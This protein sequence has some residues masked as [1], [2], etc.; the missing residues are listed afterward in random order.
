MAKRY[1]AKVE[2]FEIDDSNG[3]GRDKDTRTIHA[4]VADFTVRATDLDALKDKLTQHIEL[5]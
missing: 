1:L 3:T 5:I 4:E 2:I